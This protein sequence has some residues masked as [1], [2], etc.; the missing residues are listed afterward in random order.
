MNHDASSRAT[1][2]TARAATSAGRAKQGTTATAAELA[3]AGC[4]FEKPALSPPPLR[5]SSSF[6]PL[7]RAVTRP[8][9]HQCAA[10]VLFGDFAAN[11][12]SND[13]TVWRAVCRG[14]WSLLPAT[15]TPGRDFVALIALQHSVSSGSTGCADLYLCSFSAFEPRADECMIRLLVR[16]SRRKECRSMPRVAD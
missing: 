6:L 4:Y 16:R 8:S 14:G 5:L 11:T 3:P 13:V 15:L 9:C 7:P 10:S 12:P 1:R 2:T